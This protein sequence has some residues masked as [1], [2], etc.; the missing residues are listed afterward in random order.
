MPNVSPKTYTEKLTLRLT[1]EMRERV[2]RWAEE[3]DQTTAEALRDLIE[4]GLP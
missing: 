2:E 3:G 4:R 1:P